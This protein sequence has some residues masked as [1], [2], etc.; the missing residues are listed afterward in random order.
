M[1]GGPRVTSRS[2]YPGT[3]PFSDSAADRALFF[4]RDDE[5]E[6]LHLRVLS[7]PLL[8]QFGRSGLG[9]TSLLQA[10][11]FPRL[12]KRAYLPVMIRLNE[13]T[14]SLLDATMRSMQ[15]SCKAEGLEFTPQDPRGVWELLAASLVW[16]GDLLL[17]PV[18]VFDQFEEV[19]TLRDAAF[20]GD[21]AAEIGALATGVPP[22]RIGAR[23]QAAKPAVKIVISL[24]EDY[25]GAL[26]EFSAAIPALFHER[27]RLDP[28]TTAAAEKAIVEPARLDAAE[29]E[30]PYAS[31]RFELAATA[32]ASMIE[33]LKG[34]SGVIEPFQLQLLC[35]HAEA[36]ASAKS[37]AAKD[38]IVTLTKNDFA[39]AQTFA[40]VLQNFYRHTLAKISS[41]V[42]R[43][44]AARLCE[45]GLLDDSGHRLMLEEGQVLGDYRVT[46]E[47]VDVL[48]RER[49]LTRERR[50]ESDFY[51]IS[52]D[53]LAESIFDARGVKLPKRVRRML[54]AA[55]VVA[56][57]V[58]AVGSVYY[59]R[60]IGNERDKADRLI[61]FLLGEQFLGEI[62]DT[63]RSAL[64]TL[65]KER[66]DQSGA[67][68]RDRHNRGLARRND[69]DIELVNGN[70]ANATHRYEEALRA[71]DSGSADAATLRELALTHERLANALSEQGR[72]QESLSHLQSAERAWRGVIGRRACASDAA[73][74]CVELANALLNAANAKQGLG[75]TNTD[76]EM[77]G[78][79]HLAADILFGAPK[80]ATLYPDSGVI[81]VLSSLARARAK[82]YRFKE[83][84][85]GAVA[86]ADE[87][88]TL[89]PQSAQA[90]VDA[91]AARVERGVLRVDDDP[92]AALGDYRNAVN[93]LDEL[94]RLDPKNRDWRRNR[95]RDQLWISNAIAQCH[96]RGQPCKS[97]E[98]LADGEAHTLEAL[99][100][101]RALAAVDR[102][103]VSLQSDVMSALQ[104][105]ARVLGAERDRDEEALL[106]LREAQRLY[107]AHP[108][109]PSDVQ[110]TIAYAG[111]LRDIGNR[112]AAMNRS[113]E[114]A[115]EVQ[116]S[117]DLLRVAHLRR[118]RDVG[119]LSESSHTPPAPMK[120]IA[121][122]DQEHYDKGIQLIERDPAA[123]L[124]ELV[125][126]EVAARD[127][128]RISPAAAGGY[129]RLQFRFKSIAEAQKRLKNDAGENAASSARVNA[130]QLAAW[131]SPTSE[132]LNNL[133]AAQTDFAH[134]LDRTGHKD[135]LVAMAQ[136][137]VV[138]QERLV[139]D[140]TPDPPAL[141][142]LGLDQCRLGEE[143]YNLKIPG[144]EEAIRSG[145]I[146][147][148][149][150]AE[151]DN[152]ANY[153]GG[154]GLWHQ[155]LANK[156]DTNQRPDA[157]RIER[158]AAIAAYRK[159]L[160]LNPADERVKGALRD[161]ERK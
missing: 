72:R 84:S 79:F 96:E 11:L 136:E 77:D 81:S 2:R 10:G 104:V 18:L 69:G 14:D 19:F 106:D 80:K 37:A 78:A 23:Q 26:E 97:Q 66:V 31:P 118:P 22:P 99:A 112:L 48:C 67:A 30:E 101:F 85:D 119:E 102:S 135:E 12:R 20:R 155:L 76:S 52:H 64:L 125:A 93:G 49:L 51:E 6:Q 149:T 61:G 42:Q 13:K 150:A 144:W 108:R 57:G 132:M 59:S 140:A 146:R 45:D 87:A 73:R 70:V 60:S 161:L 56:L 128:I 126:S 157:A 156:L 151:R 142:R 36:I 94:S 133:V 8:V 115:E 24:R 47:T 75:E 63:G 152:N 88:S 55:A 16:R 68:E 71:F 123:A 1:N 129:T 95:A 53:R 82:A 100:Q 124:R 109:D 143:R 41:I 9:K 54:W 89:R 15:E 91:L 86:L 90:R 116:R 44:R 107:L 28:F 35:R 130:A 158:T 145:L 122:S 46:R 83:D 7:V 139:N 105:H 5:A 103:N 160:S 92:A 43:K 21:V 98:S 38:G 58:V 110:G 27:L 25:L 113:A 159:A 134:F 39:G 114:A 137:A 131:L 40:S 127:L 141:A 34:K 111:V 17:T 138:V 62:R 117:N 147:I 33:Y 121:A 4:G 3:R 154:A 120:E 65:V 50:H 148:E 32:L 29:G 74:D 153:Y